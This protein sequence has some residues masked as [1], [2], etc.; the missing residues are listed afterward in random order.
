MGPLVYCTDVSDSSLISSGPRRY[1]GSQCQGGGD[2]TVSG[3]YLG[4]AYKEDRVTGLH[5]NIARL[6][7]ASPES[8]DCSQFVSRAPGPITGL[9]DAEQKGGTPRRRQ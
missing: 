2:S 3:L 7:R 4:R 6:R 8:V 9:T 1:F 5:L